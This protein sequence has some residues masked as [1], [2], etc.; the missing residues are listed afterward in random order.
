MDPIRKKKK[1]LDNYARYTSI[2]LQMLVIIVAGVVGG[3]KLDEWLNLKFP[4]FTILL[5]ILSVAIAIY[6]AIRDFLKSDKTS[7][8][9]DREK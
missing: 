9:N 3:W 8:D 2:A 1:Y 7:N 4:V 6:S 5:S